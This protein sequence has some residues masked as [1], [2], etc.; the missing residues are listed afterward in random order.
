MLDVNEINSLKD[1]M[2]EQLLFT[3]FNGRQELL[4]VYGL[5][6]LMILREQQVY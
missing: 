1:E 4:N 3:I 2:D 5:V 6:I